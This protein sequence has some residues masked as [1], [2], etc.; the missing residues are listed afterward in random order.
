MRQKNIM[1][2]G[3]VALALGTTGCIGGDS[4]SSGNGNGNGNGNGSGSSELEIVHARDVYDGDST[5]LEETAPLATDDD[6]AL[7]MDFAYF[8]YL[9]E[10]AMDSFEVVTQQNREDDE[11]TQQTVESDCHLHPGE[12]ELEEEVSPAQPSPGDTVTMTTTWTTHPDDGYCIELLNH[13]APVVFHGEVTQVSETEY[14]NDGSVGV[15]TSVT[16]YEDF[17]MEW[18]SLQVGQELVE[19]ILSGEDHRGSLGDSAGGD[20]ENYIAIA[21]DVELPQLG[22]GDELH[23]ILRNGHFGTDMEQVI[24]MELASPFLEGTVTTN[25]VDPE[26]FFDGGSD[27]PQTC[28]GGPLNNAEDST[29]GS[30]EIR[31]DAVEYLGELQGISDCGEFVLSAVAGGGSGGTYMLLDQLLEQ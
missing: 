30:V 19:V 23:T 29:N 20:V 1:T 27:T 5:E 17:S 21:L 16:T 31:A 3:L 14:H 10:T 25:Q 11:A 26:T 7:A 15:T 13:D 18:L 6:A 2:T 8:A 28:D 22:D 24:D 12:V 9:V 4:G